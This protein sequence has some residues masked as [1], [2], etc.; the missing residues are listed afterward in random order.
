VDIVPAFRTSFPLITLVRGDDKVEPN[1]TFFVRLKSPT[2]ATLGD[3]EGVCT[4]LNDDT[5]KPK[6]GHGHD[7]DDD[8]DHGH[9]HHD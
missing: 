5:K 7:D 2:G 9:G 6:G 1:E 4:I 8:D 3:A